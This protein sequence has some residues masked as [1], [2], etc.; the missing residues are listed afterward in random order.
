MDKIRVF[1]AFSGYGTTTLSLR[2]LEIPYEVVGVSEVDID[3]IISYGSLRYDESDLDYIARDINIEDMRKE[4]ISKNI[5]VSPKTN[6][7]L[8]PKMRRKRVETLYKFNKAI[9]NYGDIK[10]LTP[11]DIPSFDY[12]SYTFPCTSISKVG[13]REGIIEGITKTSLVYETKKIIEYHMPKYLVMENVGT[14]IEKRYEGFLDEW[15]TYL[16][17]LGYFSVI[18][19][20]NATEFNIP[21][22]RR[23]LFMISVLNEDIKELKEIPRKELKL[24]LRDFLEDDIDEKYYLKGTQEF[25][26]KNSFD[27]E[28]KGNKYSFE[29][30]IEKNAGIAKTITTRAGYRMED[31]YVLDLDINLDKLA[32]KKKNLEIIEQFLGNERPKIRKLTPRECFRLM[33]LNDFDIYRLITSGVAESNLY[34]LAGNGVVKQCLDEIHKILFKEYIEV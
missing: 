14:L 31:N 2:D 17:N 33:G 16:S 7:S 5:G 3:A 11:S 8:I 34:K 4:L 20:L 18:H 29:P 13:K 23:R 6:E 28:E 30:H 9:N 25:F 12:L 32:F 24:S 27:M 15:K 22:H 26:I 1:E 10:L 21:Q 19:I